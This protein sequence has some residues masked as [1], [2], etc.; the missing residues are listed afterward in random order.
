MLTPHVGT[1][2]GSVKS[3]NAVDPK[4]MCKQCMDGSPECAAQVRDWEGARN[5]E[6]DGATRK[7]HLPFS[8]PLRLVSSIR[9]GQAQPVSCNANSLHSTVSTGRE[10][11]AFAA[12]QR[13]QG[14]WWPLQLR[15][16]AGERLLVGVGR[17]QG[18]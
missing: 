5:R 11:L 12:A 15:E 10:K 14:R 8:L 17:E 13:D 4:L 2:S 6:A 16:G 3:N 1:M 9:K 7:Q 18:R